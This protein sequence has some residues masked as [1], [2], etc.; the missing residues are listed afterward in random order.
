MAL[1]E[2]LKNRQVVIDD[3]SPHTAGADPVHGLH[4]ETHGGQ[5][6]EGRVRLL[7]EDE[8]SIRR[9]IRAHNLGTPDLEVPRPARS[10][11]MRARLAGAKRTVA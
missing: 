3:S 5:R 11:A 9:E 2:V 8:F 1:V 6:T 10:A 4:I 7:P